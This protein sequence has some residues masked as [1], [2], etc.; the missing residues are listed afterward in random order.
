M[1]RRRVGGGGWR[2]KVVREKRMNSMRGRA[3]E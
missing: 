3:E 2:E 1:G